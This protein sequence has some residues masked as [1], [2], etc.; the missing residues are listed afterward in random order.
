M[1]RC[2]VKLRPEDVRP[3]SEEDPLRRFHAAIRATAT[4]KNYTTMLRQILC[5]IFEDI[6]HGAFEERVKEFVEIGRN[7]QEKMLGILL[8]LSRLVCER[9]KKDRSDPDYLNPSSVP[10]YFFILMKLLKANGVEVN[11]NRVKQT[12]PELDNVD[13]TRGW[14]REEIRRMLD[15]AKNSRERAAILILA[16]SGMRVG[17]MMLRWGDLTRIY[18][19]DGRMVM[20]EDLKGRVSGELACVAVRVYRNSSEEY[21]TFIT[22]EAYRALMEYAAE[23]EAKVGR[24]PGKV[25]PIFKN[26]QRPP[27]M[28]NVN[29]ISGIMRRITSHAGVRKRQRDNPARWEVPLL[30]GFRRFFNKTMKDAKTRE[31]A[32]SALT[33]IEFMVGHKG[34]TPLDR[35]YYKTNPQELAETYV[36]VIPNLTISES[37]R[38]NLAG[39]NSDEA[40][41]GLDRPDDRNRRLEWMSDRLRKGAFAGS[42]NPSE[43]T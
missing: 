33:K 1:R 32:L 29:N 12:F 42:D 24:K 15:H 30:R 13:D 16:S 21:V 9:T 37:E 6:L 11:W 23:W 3:V 17:G 18:G 20:E 25:D 8:G 7:E 22:P 39:R 31:S 40:V 10:I 36:N 26:T 28:I 19:V 34:I 35:S 41:L 2:R 27:A 38:L 43:A 5:D 14:T 4:D